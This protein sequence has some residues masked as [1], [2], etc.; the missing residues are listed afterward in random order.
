MGISV[1]SADAPVLKNTNAILAF[2]NAES[3][4]PKTTACIHCGRCENHSPIG[5]VPTEKEKAYTAGNGEQLEKLQVNLCMECG[6]C[7]Y[8]CPA[9]RPLVQTNKLAK[10]N[11]RD[12]IAKKQ[13]KAKEESGK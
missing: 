3:T 11:L 5:L 13:A 9:K 6:C 8:I 12:Y 10:A 1:P 7:S 2:G 4:V